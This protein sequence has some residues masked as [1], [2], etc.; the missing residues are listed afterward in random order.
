[1]VDYFQYYLGLQAR[2]RSQVAGYYQ[3]YIQA[4]EAA[5]RVVARTRTAFNL[6]Q[7]QSKLSQYL[8]QQSQINTNRRNAVSAAER[9]A[10][11]IMPTVSEWYRAI[12]A[13]GQ[14][15]SDLYREAERR[16]RAIRGVGNIA[17]PIAA[18]RQDQSQ[19]YAIGFSNGVFV[20]RFRE[21]A[22]NARELAA[23]LAG[24]RARASSEFDRIYGG[25]AAQIGGRINA[26][27]DL[28]SRLKQQLG[29]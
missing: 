2:A 14:S 3:H 23:R 21:R 29:V 26:Q 4:Q 15:G 27:R 28:V 22:E 20:Y 7:A 6:E 24:V 13:S 19:S 1:M 8:G 9:A 5:R 11:Q 17:G 16:G 18:L 12:F 25:T 10:R